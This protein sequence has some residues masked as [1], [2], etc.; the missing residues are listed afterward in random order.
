ML[1]YAHV[2][3][4]LWG[5]AKFRKLT[6]APPNGRDLWLY[7]LTS[8]HSTN[9]PGILVARRETVAADLGWSPE[10]LD[11]V[12]GELSG[13][14]PMAVADWSS[15]L[16][17]LPRA[18]R[19]DPPSSPNHVRSWVRIWSELPES[20]LLRRAAKTIGSELERVNPAFAAVFLEG[21][22]KGYPKPSGRPTPSPPRSRPL[23]LPLPLPLEESPN[24]LRLARTD[25]APSAA[26]D[27]VREIFDHWR[28]VRNHPGAK[29][30]AKRKAK[31]RSRLAEKF[32]PADLCRAVDNIA[33]SRWHCGENP[34]GKV[35][36]G[37]EVVFRDAAQVE[38]FLDM[39]VPQSKPS[40]ATSLDPA[41]ATRRAEARDVAA[42]EAA[43][44]TLA[45][46]RVKL[47]LPEEPEAPAGPPNL[48]GVFS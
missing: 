12:W 1:K 32:A 14:D 29:L 16:V 7:L 6:T 5:D 25:D 34:D 30:D 22:P 9:I 46:A 42:R 40:T 39:A 37:I 36:D 26:R 33:L 47:G 19:H 38:K 20:A 41:E 17:W 31:I 28:E 4:R 15:G 18:V 27:P 21:L 48:A 13:A 3:R 10:A 2:S 45:A 35:Y 24:P 43:R 11:A 44:R 23:P 8:P